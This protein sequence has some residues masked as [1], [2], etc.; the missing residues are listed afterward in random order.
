MPPDATVSHHRGQVV[1][2]AIFDT[3][4]TLI[5]ERGYAFSV[6]EIA[7]TAGVHKSTI[8]P[9]MRLPWNWSIGRSQRVNSDPTSTSRPTTPRPVV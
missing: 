1:L 4:L 6:D 3:T 5:A 9:D 8:Y 2:D 7:E